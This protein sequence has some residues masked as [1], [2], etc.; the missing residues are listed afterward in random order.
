MTD[1]LRFLEGAL[2]DL[3]RLGQLRSPPTTDEIASGPGIVLSSNDYLGLASDP[4]PP[5]GRSGSGASALLGGYQ[6]AHLLAERALAELVGLEDALMFSSGYAA[7]VGVISALA[8]RGDLI[9]S[10]ALNHASI[11]DGCRLSGAEVRIARHLDSSSV[12]TALADGSR[13]RRRLV[14]T[15]S[16]FSMDGDLAD[17][18]GLSRICSATDTILVVDEAHALGV[19]GPE[20]RGRCAATE[21]VPD[22][23]VGTLGKAFG[24][25]GAFVAGPRRLKHWL[26]NRARS[27]VFS[28]AMSPALAAAVPAR[29]S[30]VKGLDDARSRLESTGRALR[31]A[32]PDPARTGVGPIIPFLVGSEA[33]AERAAAEAR[34]RGVVVR[35]VR[36]PTVPA[37]GSRLRIVASSVISPTDLDVACRVLREVSALVGCT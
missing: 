19:F 30:K 10:D 22:V 27:F 36:P 6:H 20:G 14:V 32:L 37:G 21:V 12:S 28:T 25:Q 4:L 9:V 18:A 16:Y 26:W 34:L 29:V 35:A 23:L 11:I 8:G 33:V 24:L 1:R 7:N 31:E 13:F 15:E 3:D 17:L 2:G 5:L